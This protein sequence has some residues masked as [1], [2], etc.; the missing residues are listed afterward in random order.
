MDQAHKQDKEDLRTLLEALLVASK[1]LQQSPIFSAKD[2]KPTIRALL[3]TAADADPIMFDDSSF[4][5]LGQLIRTLKTH[6]KELEKSQD[7]SFRTLLRRQITYYKVSKLGYVIEAEIQAYFD[8]ES[9]R[10]LVTTLQESED[11]DQKVEV[12]DEFEERLSR[13]FDREFQELVLKAKVFTVLESLL[14]DSTCSK[15]VRERAALAV[16]ALVRFNKNVFVG[17][18]LMGPIIEAL[19]SMSTCC[20][21]QVLTSLIKLVRIPLIDEIELEGEIPGI[22][23][24][25]SSEDLGI[26]VAAL[27]CVCEIAYCGR[28]EVI[29]VMLNE[30]LI[31]KLMELQRS[32]HG[33]NLTETQKHRGNGSGVSSLDM[34]GEN[35][36]FSGCVAR[37]AVQVEVGEGLTTQERKEFKKV[38]LRKVTEASVSEAEGATIFAEVLWGGSWP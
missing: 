31:E 26:G 22:I 19:V 11:E 27:D 29:E 28:A 8:Q 16:V 6:L 30:G 12:L 13:G 10:N 14:C 17:L 4:F 3:A 21:I 34:E 23:N 2:P 1:D 20:S 32:K 15:R 18:V 37:F 36:P 35:G 25:L 7:R 33:D 5:K 9:V 24:L 38:V